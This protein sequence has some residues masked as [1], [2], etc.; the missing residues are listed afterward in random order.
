MKAVAYYRNS[1]S[2]E[3]QKLSIEMQKDHV[4]KLAKEKNL[5]IE[6]EYC[7]DETSA[8]KTKVEERRHMSR[9]LDDIEKG[10]IKTLIVYS[11]CRLARNVH[12]YMQIYKALQDKEIE[13]LFAGEHEFPMLYT[14]EAE[15]IERIM[16]SFNQHEADNLVKKLKDAKRTKA[17]QG[18]HAVGPISFG[19]EPHSEKDGDWRIIPDEAKAIKEIY[20]LFLR[21]DFDSV[22][23]FVDLVNESGYRFKEKKEWTYGNVRNALRNAIYKGTRKYKDDVENLAV[24]VPHLKIVDDDVWDQVQNKL[25]KFT[26]ESAEEEE[27]I[28]FLLKGFITC[29]ECQQL[30]KAKKVQRNGQK[31]GIYQ[32][33]D[34]PKIK[35][36][37]ELLEQEI[38]LKANKFFDEILSPV[39]KKFLLE[40]TERQAK[41]YGKIENDLEKVKSKLKDQIGSEFDVILNAESVSDLPRGIKETLNELVQISESRERFQDKFFDLKETLKE[42]NDFHNEFQETVEIIQPDMDKEM[43]QELL[44]DIIQGIYAFSEKEI[45]VILKHPHID[46][47][48]GKEYIELG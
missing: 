19:Y 41:Y 40:T 46:E 22:N 6:D 27:E 2:K 31:I 3:K 26:R 7:D 21:E 4:K 12:Q 24:A 9:L 45:T 18:L 47:L 5:L 42:L 32:C 13:V 10:R 29:T 48:G 39:F 8:R 1:I 17:R 25:L 38:I 11:R 30:L 14:I 20:E 15:L 44:Q 36:N 16:A 35:Y 43:V 34:H 28:F 23:Q 33:N 37:H